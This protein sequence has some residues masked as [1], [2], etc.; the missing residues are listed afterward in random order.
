MLHGIEEDLPKQVKWNGGAGVVGRWCSVGYQGGI[1]AKETTAYPALTF[2]A[3]HSRLRL[4]YIYNCC[5]SISLSCACNHL[6]TI[7]LSCA[8]GNV[9]QIENHSVFHIGKN[10]LRTNI[11][12]TQ[13][14]TLRSMM[15]RSTERSLIT[16]SH[17]TNPSLFIPHFIN[18]ST[19]SI[20]LPLLPCPTFTTQLDITQL[21]QLLITR[22]P[23]FTYL[24]SSKTSFTALCQ[25]AK[26]LISSFL[27]YSFSPVL[28]PIP[29]SPFV[30]Y[31]IITYSL[32]ISLFVSLVL[33]TIIIHKK[34]MIRE[35]NLGS[36]ANRMKREEINNRQIKRSLDVLEED[37]VQSDEGIEALRVVSVIDLQMFQGFFDEED[38]KVVVSFFERL[39]GKRVS[40]TNKLLPTMMLK[41]NFDGFPNWGIIS[42]PR[43]FVYPQLAI[44]ILNL[45]HYIACPQNYITQGLLECSGTRR[46]SLSE[47]LKLIKKP[48]DQHL[49]STFD[50]LAQHS[51]FIRQESSSAVN[52]QSSHLKI[53]MKSIQHCLSFTS[54][55]VTLSFKNL[56]IFPSKE[57]LCCH[58][59]I[60]SNPHQAVCSHLFILLVFSLLTI[61]PLNLLSLNPFDWYAF[62]F[63]F[64]S[65]SPTFFGLS[66]CFSVWSCFLAISCSAFKL[67]LLPSSPKNR[68]KL[69]T[70]YSQHKTGISS[71]YDQVKRKQLHAS[72]MESSL[73]PVYS[74]MG[75]AVAAA[76]ADQSKRRKVSSGLFFHWRRRE[77]GRGVREGGRFWGLK[78][79]LEEDRVDKS[80][81]RGRCRGQDGP[82]ERQGGPEGWLNQGGVTRSGNRRG[83]GGTGTQWE[84]GEFAG[85]RC[86]KSRDVE[87]G[88]R[89]SYHTII[90][91]QEIEGETFR[92]V[93]TSR[94]TKAEHSQSLSG[95]QCAKS[96][97]GSVFLRSET[98]E[99]LIHIGGEHSIPLIFKKILFPDWLAFSYPHH[100]CLDMIMG[101]KL[102]EQGAIEDLGCRRL[103]QYL[104]A[105]EW[106]GGKSCKQK[107]APHCKENLINCMQ[108]TCSMLQPSFPPSS[109]CCLLYNFWHSHCAV[110]TV[111]V[112]QSLLPGTFCMSTAGKFQLKMTDLTSKSNLLVENS[113]KGLQSKQCSEILPF[114]IRIYSK[115]EIDFN[116]GFYFPLWIELI[117]SLDKKKRKIKINFPALVLIGTLCTQNW[118][119]KYN[120]ST[121]RNQSIIKK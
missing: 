66:S 25:F 83:F 99:Y 35:V 76:E 41:R 60:S 81:F 29:A 89:L 49:K 111:T 12:N 62:F 9:A 3:F 85:R 33:V 119:I 112:H 100:L 75:E 58:P 47:F 42:S 2:P 70:T 71:V 11:H 23:T 30:P 104:D 46:F 87:G 36:K 110:C 54:L 16:T 45:D 48:Q 72:S 80:R 50:Q 69:C 65:F 21:T 86:G 101:K 120:I 106:K 93:K 5:L 96:K 92:G 55:T 82:A 37:C 59:P 17:S 32:I 31:C 22:S 14:Q 74:Y 107:Q 57:P 79:T 8:F 77:C 121:I 64:S 13:I 95:F 113:K 103:S 51:S 98:K 116:R 38:K 67:K 43:T 91:Q 40:R 28:L 63:L 44:Y 4:P 88:Y 52:T 118:G 90:S 94:S 39:S 109:T 19:P 1:L 7:P 18:Y 117:F 105:A 15:L 34:K 115:F 27:S 78:R 84:R 97:Q 26:S 114:F 108:L 6:F 56:S 61:S 24:N 68:L 73:L 102:R 10:L 20:L 53:H